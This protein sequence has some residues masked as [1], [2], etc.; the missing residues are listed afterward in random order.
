MNK[1]IHFLKRL[2]KEAIKDFIVSFYR[3]NKYYLQQTTLTYSECIESP[4]R[5]FK[6][7]IN[8]LIRLHKLFTK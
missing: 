3:C 1:R 7:K 4:I 8:D 5:K 6:E 2:I